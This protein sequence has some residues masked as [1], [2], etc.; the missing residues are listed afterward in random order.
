M[1]DVEAL[2]VPATVVVVVVVVFV[3][4]LAAK[5]CRYTN[6]PPTPAVLTTAKVVTVAST[7]SATFVAVRLA[8]DE[9]P[10][11]NAVLLA[12]F[13]EAVAASSDCDT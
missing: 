3:V 1:V 10:A 6:T 8:T 11:A 13:P 9:F 7:T 2:T 12:A 4:V 5:Y